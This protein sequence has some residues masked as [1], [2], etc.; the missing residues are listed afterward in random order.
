MDK[1]SL[2]ETKINSL[3]LSENFDN[4]DENI[5]AVIND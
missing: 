3:F 2:P 5:R 4:L 1:Y